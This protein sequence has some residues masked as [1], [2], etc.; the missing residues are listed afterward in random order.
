MT[1]WPGS[2][3]RWSLPPRLSLSQR[4]TV[5]ATAATAATPQV[6]MPQH[7]P[8]IPLLFLLLLQ[9]LTPSFLCMAVEVATAAEER[10]AEEATAEERKGEEVDLEI[11]SRDLEVAYL[12]G[13]AA[14]AKV[15][16]AAAAA[17]AQ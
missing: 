15:K 7:P 13:E 1:G 14:R 4:L 17:A 10:R 11:F 2:F 8:T 6:T 3:G 9:F 5:Q 16:V 12:E